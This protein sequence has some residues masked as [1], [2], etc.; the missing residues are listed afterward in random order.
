MGGGGGGGRFKGGSRYF[1]ENKRGI[2][3][4]L[5]PKRKDHSNLLG[6]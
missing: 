6:K 2:S 5:E 4:N 3:R 1:Y